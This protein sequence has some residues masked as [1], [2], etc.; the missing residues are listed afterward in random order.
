MPR[1]FV[2]Q[3]FDKGKFDKRFDAVF[4]PAITKAGLEPYR[5]D[6]DPGVDIPIDTIESEIR[7]SAICLADITTDNPNVWYELGYAIAYG[8]DVVL[9]CSTERTTKF[10]F[11]VQHR[12]IINY[13]PESPQD[14]ATLG[15]DITAHTKA[16]IKK[17]Q[18]VQ[19]LSSL[20]PL[21]ETEGL[22][23]TE[24]IALV[25]IMEKSQVLDRYTFIDSVLEDMRNAG[26]TDIAGTLSIHSLV[27]KELVKLAKTIQGKDLCGMTQK[28]VD[29]LINNQDK[30]KLKQQQ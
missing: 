24:I 22:N 17:Q 10:P 29:W 25:S 9:V 23:S 5:V 3:P 30:L 14:F 6:R 20:S 26:F 11:D 27:K 28:G 7:S 8:R 4:A 2:I 19:T 12:N 16:L 18:D 15:E 21:E 1:C 13:A